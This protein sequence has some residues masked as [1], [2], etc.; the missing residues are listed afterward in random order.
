MSLLIIVYL[1]LLFWP[2]KFSLT[3]LTAS[4]IADIKSASVHAL[5]SYVKWVIGAGSSAEL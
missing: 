1:Y 2:R 4:L 3:I 5:G